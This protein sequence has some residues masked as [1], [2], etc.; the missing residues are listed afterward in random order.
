MKLYKN[1][2]VMQGRLL[3]KYKGRYQAHPLGYWQNEFPIASKFS[4]SNIEFIFDYNDY[5]LN[6]LMSQDGLNEILELSNKYNINV[7]SVCADFFM[8][9]PI[10]CDDETIALKSVSVLK[11]LISACGALPVSDIVVPCVD[12][13]S[14]KT[15]NQKFNL[16]NRLELVYDMLEKYNI[17][18]ALETDLNPK[19]FNDL[20]KSIS[21]EKITVNYDTGNSASLG[22]NPNEE[23]EYY[24][25]KITDIHIKDRLLNDGSVFLGEGSTNFEECFELIKSIKFNGPIIMQAFRNDEGVDIFKRQLNWLNE[26]FLINE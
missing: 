17:N 13:S 24:G 12:Q 4:L 15:Q 14:L 22:Y 20:L 9:Q 19:D 8:E 25:D 7:N 5:L 10:H 1:L 26:N 23:F 6:P 3:P 21:H 18:I 2:G 16:A 11:K